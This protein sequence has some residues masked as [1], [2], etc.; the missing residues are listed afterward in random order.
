MKLL[1]IVLLVLAAVLYAAQMA[2]LLSMH[3]SDPFGR[4]M[5]QALGVFLTVGLGLLL[6][7]LFALARGKGAFPSFSGWAI[8]LLLPAS[9]AA[10]LVT[11][12]LFKSTVSPRWLILPVAVLPVLLALFAIALWVP[13]LRSRLLSF[14]MNCIVWGTVLL[15]SALPWIFAVKFA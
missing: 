13:D 9:L 8:L 5:A 7:G 6:A 3:S 15:L 12:N 1:F 11:N 10:M 2:N 14:E 4:G